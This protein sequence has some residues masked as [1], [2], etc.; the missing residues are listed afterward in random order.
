MREQEVFHDVSRSGTPIPT[1]LAKALAGSRFTLAFLLGCHESVAQPGAGAS[2]I[3]KAQ[4]TP[5]PPSSGSVEAQQSTS[6]SAGS[7]SSVNTLNSTIQV[8]GSY[9]GSIPTPRRPKTAHLTI[10]DAIHRGPVQSRRRDRQPF[11]EAGARAAA[12]AISQMLPNIY[13]TLTRRVPRS[14]CRPRLQRFRIRRSHCASD[15]HRP[16]PLLHSA[17]N[18][19]EDLSLTVFTTSASRTHRWR[20]RG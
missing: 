18:V 16:F 20:R 10:A 17:G 9:Q 8:S 19:S 3:P 15:Y 6:G 5:L 11:R 7:G 4:Q 14:T 1:D 13:A 2:S 12:G